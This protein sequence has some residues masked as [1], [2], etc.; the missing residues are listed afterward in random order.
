MGFPIPGTQSDYFRT[1]IYFHA[2]S[3][4][5]EIQNEGRNVTLP[6]AAFWVQA[7]RQCFL[8]E[9]TFKYLFQKWLKVR[10]FC[11]HFVSVFFSHREALD[12]FEPNK[13]SYP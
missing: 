9:A 13:P 3:Q 8:E 1:I 6:L 2:F 4:L 11:L 7:R 12:D 10:L 5:K